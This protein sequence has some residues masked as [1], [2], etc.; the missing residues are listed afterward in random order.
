M[1]RF[2]DAPA[3]ERC[4]WTIK[5]R[6]GSG[7][8]CGRRRVVGSLCTQHAK[9]AARWSC[10]YCGGNNELPPDRRADCGRPHARS[11]TTATAGNKQRNAKGNNDASDEMGC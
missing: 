9:I 7:A 11:T 5:L 2:I 10:E 3:D 1:S 4:E 8:Q 6:D